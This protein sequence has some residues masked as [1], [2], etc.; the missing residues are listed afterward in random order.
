MT[1]VNNT[2]CESL[3]DARA[4][5]DGLTSYFHA[6]SAGVNTQSDGGVIVARCISQVVTVNTTSVTV[7]FGWGTYPPSCARLAQSGSN[8]NL[9]YLEPDQGSSLTYC[10]NAT[11]MGQASPWYAGNDNNP[12]SVLVPQAATPVMTY[13]APRLGAQR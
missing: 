8:G 2:M 4:A 7:A 10:A 3:F 5:R 11:T 12:A 6:V 9:T 13:V 1:I